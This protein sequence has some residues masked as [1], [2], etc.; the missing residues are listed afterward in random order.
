[1]KFKKMLT[2]L[3]STSLGLPPANAQ[4]VTVTIDD[5][6]MDRFYDFKENLDR[7][8][9][10]F[11][12]EY[13]QYYPPTEIDGKKLSERF[14]IDKM[15]FGE[16]NPKAILDDIENS[17]N[18]FLKEYNG[19]Q[20]ID[21]KDRMRL[22]SIALK[23]ISSSLKENSAVQVDFV[24]THLLLRFLREPDNRQA[25]WLLLETFRDTKLGA[26][27]REIIDR[28]KSYW[29]NF[30]KALGTTILIDLV[31]LATM[32]KIRGTNAFAKIMANLEKRFPSLFGK[33]KK[34]SDTLAGG[35]QKLTLPDPKN[36]SAQYS[37]TFET[38]TKNL[39]S[40]L[41]LI[42]GVWRRTK[43]SIPTYRFSRNPK[44]GR[45]NMRPISITQE[46]KDF[47]FKN[48]LKT[49]PESRRKQLKWITA[50]LGVAAVG[51]ALRQQ[52][53]SHDLLWAKDYSVLPQEEMDRYLS[54][55][56]SLKLQ[57]AAADLAQEVMNRNYVTLADA[58][59]LYESDAEKLNDLFN[60]YALLMIIAPTLTQKQVISRSKEFDNGVVAFAFDKETSTLTMTR[61]FKDRVEYDYWPC[62]AW[63]EKNIETLEVS[64][65]DALLNL[66]SAKDSILAARLDQIWR[67]NLEKSED[68]KTL[69]E[70]P[71]IDIKNLDVNNLSLRRYVQDGLIAESAFELI[72]RQAERILELSPEA[73]EVAV[74]NLVKD[75][76]EGQ[77]VNLALL[78]ALQVELNRGST[79]TGIVNAPLTQISELK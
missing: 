75:Y 10:N 23:I 5:T 17:Q 37:K 70:R 63:S 38:E 51:G 41:V 47:W 36:V 49:T 9:D 48:L 20:T 54:H 58:D 26:G 64:L 67:Y 27:Q 59:S 11:I 43:P 71:F 69:D 8:I 25:I 61:E 76:N 21:I 78:I 44:L 68:L 19:G 77:Y 6:D 14:M 42:D 65:I 34:P 55:A 74:S 72:N 24:I 3:L 15:V 57:C 60:Q 7:S 28:N 29:Y 50:T 79:L 30:S 31:I 62:R 18:R 52:I 33:V 16:S 32:P 53:Y 2:I 35:V 22:E 13:K 56:A 4:N 46:T 39:P 1:M 40:D 45:S 73:F 12:I 66:E